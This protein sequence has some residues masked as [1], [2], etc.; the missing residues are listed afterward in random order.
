MKVHCHVIRDLI[1]LVIDDVA[2]PESKQ[3]VFQH[4]ETCAH[5]RE[6]FQN[7]SGIMTKELPEPR[8]EKVI[9]SIKLR[10][11]YMQLLV[12]VAGIALGI[13]LT[14]SF[15][16]FYNLLIM[17]ALGALAYITLKNKWFWV[18]PV[19][20]LLVYLYHI[21]TSFLSEGFYPEILIAASFFGFIYSGLAVIGVVIF[22]LL[23]F[24]FG[25][26]GNGDE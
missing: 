26:D 10:L 18:L 24:A 1:P 2:S 8:D 15:G 16:M 17:P 23:Q 4:L 21:I 25:K 19:I 22:W 14:N 3:L 5:C 13:G 9:R 6:E 12:L 7:I 11:Y 20:F